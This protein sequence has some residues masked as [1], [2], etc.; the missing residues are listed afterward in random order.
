MYPGG[1]SGHFLGQKTRF[2]ASLHQAVGRQKEGPNGQK[3]F[4]SRSEALTDTQLR[5]ATQ[6]CFSK[7]SSAGSN[8]PQV[9]G[10]QRS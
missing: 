1:T 6:K 4:G 3:S 7:S 2:G 8:D 5:R 9:K 10:G